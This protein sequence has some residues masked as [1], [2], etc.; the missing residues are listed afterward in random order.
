MRFLPLQRITYIKKSCMNCYCI[1]ICQILINDNTV[2]IIEF[3]RW[4]N[5]ISS[6]FDI[7]T[8]TAEMWPPGVKIVS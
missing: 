8:P 3:L 6:S 5:P 7:K 1:D 4:Q 2:I